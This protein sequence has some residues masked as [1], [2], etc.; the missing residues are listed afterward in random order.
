[1]LVGTPGAFWVWASWRVTSVEPVPKI[2]YAGG[3]PVKPIVTRT[4]PLGPGPIR[5]TE[6][7]AASAGR[8]SVEAATATIAAAARRFTTRT[9]FGPAPTT[10]CRP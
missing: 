9:A 1:M 3:G 7:S 8:G 2:R 10:A 6:S 4:P 5:R